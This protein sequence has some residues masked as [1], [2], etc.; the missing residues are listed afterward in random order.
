[1]HAGREPDDK[2]CSSAD[3]LK[4]T[5][6]VVSVLTSCLAE[7]TADVKTCNP[8]GTDV[9]VAARDSSPRFPFLRFWVKGGT[10][11]QQMKECVVSVLLRPISG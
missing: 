3:V 9:Q 10:A 7:I 5:P 1:M 6:A 8:F 11:I 2:S 4:C